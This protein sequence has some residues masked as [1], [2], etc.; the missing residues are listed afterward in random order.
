MKVYRILS[1]L[2]YI[3]EET[4]VGKLFNCFHRTGFWPQKVLLNKASSWK[5]LTHDLYV[6]NKNIH[7]TEHKHLNKSNKA[8]QHFFF[9]FRV[10][11]KTV[12]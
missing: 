7:L 3:A 11:A 10:K 5:T 6:C 4:L 12:I 9:L 2:D 8:Q 1:F